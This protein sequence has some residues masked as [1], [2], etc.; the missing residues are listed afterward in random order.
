MPERA[1]RGGAQHDKR[2]RW[3]S[4]A[5]LAAALT[6]PQPAIGAPAVVDIV[7]Q[8]V[9]ALDRQEI[10]SLSLTLGV[11]LFAVVT[12]IALVRT[13]SHAATTLAETRHE[14]AAA[15]EAADRAL[16]LLLAEPQVVV[17]WRDPKGEPEILGDAMSLMGLPATRRVLAF[18][19]WLDADQAHVLEA[20]TDALRKRGQTFSM[21][22]VSNRGN[23]VEAAGRPIG[24]AAVLRLKE[25]TGAKLDHAALAER[26][27]RL[28]RDLEQ[29]R[30]LLE[31]VP[32]P[33]WLRDEAGRLAFAN[34]AYATAVEAKDAADAV[35]RE[36]ELLDRPTRDEAAQA[37]ADQRAF[38]K[39]V[40]VVV[41]GQRR[42]VD[43]IEFGNAR[44]A[45]GI[46]FDATE[47]ATV[48]ADLSR[49]VTA[50]RRT[51]DQLATAVAIFGA[52][53]RL[54]FHNAAY[55]SL[56]KLDATFLEE[57]PSDGAVLDRLRN[58]RKL[59][60]QVDFRAW[61]AELFEAYRS[62]EPKEHVWHLPGGRILRVVTSPN[63]E[64]GVT[65]LFDDISERIAL[66]S[67]YNTVIHAQS[68]TLDALNEAVAVFGSDGRLKLHN[69]VFERL[70]HLSAKMLADN[71]HI[72]AVAGWC[73]PLVALDAESRAP[74]DPWQA[75]KRAVTAI[76]RRDPVT[77]RIERVD[78]SVIDCAAV[79]LPD[80][81]TLVT[82]R[83]VTDS[84]R[85]ERA[86]VERNEAL[87][88]AD[89][90]KN[91]FVRNVSYELRS[92]LTTIIG[93]AQL[94]TDAAIGPLNDKQRDY[95]G[96]INE[97]SVALLA[98][99]DDIL[100]LATIDAGA[101]TLELGQVDVR[102]TVEAAV[103]GVR[104]R[105]AANELKLDLRVPRDVGHFVAD[106]KRVRQVL[107]NLL[108]NAVGFS[109]RGGTV[110]LA[111]ERQAAGVVF[112]VSDGGPG[113]PPELK[114]RIFGRFESHPLGSKHRG[115]GLGLSIVRALIE[116][117]HGTVA[118]DSEPGRGTVVTCTF[119][120]DAAAGREA[121]E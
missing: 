82:F 111:A 98:I 33:I 112:R 4:A 34:R 120:T 75:I 52:D 110:T 100:D 40:P 24:G 88:Q 113:I 7:L 25:I 59:P 23:H 89:A 86:L 38:A 5:L 105:L 118:I 106:G 21:S 87:L 12:A 56:F 68:E 66:E 39:R 65:Y 72:D 49:I 96:H 26:H 84:V 71:P 121:A 102:A 117:H 62:P 17:V 104:D 91:A 6:F 2:A 22:L 30:A 95:L 27:Q 3:L 45:A 32:A 93:F 99:I 79:P 16:A 9:A 46:G 108:S 70:W 50:H 51:L 109:P 77:E 60:E 80:G 74:L 43:V 107:F 115:P 69:P 67:R 97:S 20:A 83:D 57:R 103:D 35:A 78:G 81:G 10:V 85:V 44:G 8:T 73:G 116:L 76:E 31:M 28:E 36:M 61:K 94:L 101:M 114:N 64:G 92:P 53:Q 41:A 19:A 54:V 14:S 11:L 29:L 42:V 18:G 119:P 58:E 1:G 15:R 63:P 48:R 37:R 13:R 90:L 55:R 47:A